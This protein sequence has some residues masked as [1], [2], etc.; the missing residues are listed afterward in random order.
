MIFEPPA[1]DYAAVGLAI[2]RARRAAG[3]TID[4]LVRRSG[5]SRRHL[6]DIEHGNK[7]PAL[8]ILYAIAVGLGV[9]GGDLFRQ[10]YQPSAAGPSG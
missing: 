3:F 5:I 4:E 2:A 6:I 9:D 8:G 7:K 1:Y 10:G